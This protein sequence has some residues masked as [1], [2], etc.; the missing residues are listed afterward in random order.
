MGWPMQDYPDE[1]SETAEMPNRIGDCVMGR[2]RWIIQVYVTSRIFTL[3]DASSNARYSSLG[4][5]A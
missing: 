2:D 5:G 3:E 1:L 4:S